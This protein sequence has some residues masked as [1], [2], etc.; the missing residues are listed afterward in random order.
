MLTAYAIFLA[1]LA[2]LTSVLTLAGGMFLTTRR[3]DHWID[4]AGGLASALLWFV[5]AFGASSLESVTDGGTI[6]VRPATPAVWLFAVF[7][8]FMVVIALKGTAILF[9]VT[10]LAGMETDSNRV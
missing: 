6:V 3:D 10:D 1:A 7:G 4:V 8:V 5:A 2:W 9:N